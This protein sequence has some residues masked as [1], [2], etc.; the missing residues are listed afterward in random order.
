M[1]SVTHLHAKSLDHLNMNVRNLAE[2]VEFYE[3]LFGFRVLKEQPEEDSKIIGNEH[4]KLCL[5]EVDEVNGSTGIAHFGIHVSN[6]SEIENKCKE[7]NIRTKYDAPLEWEKSRS[8]YIY[9][10]SGYVIE[11][12]EA[13]GGGL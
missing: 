7:M 1:A 8:I 5:Y 13:A 3:K 6:F 2:S 10:P 9:D 4:I 11:L 12:T